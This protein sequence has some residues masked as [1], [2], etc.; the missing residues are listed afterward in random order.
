[1]SRSASI[2]RT[3]NGRMAV[4]RP[5]DSALAAHHYQNEMLLMG[6]D[7]VNSPRSSTL[8]NRMMGRGVRQYRELISTTE[9]T[10]IPIVF[11]SNGKDDY[12]QQMVQA[13][14]RVQSRVRTVR[15]LHPIVNLRKAATLSGAINNIEFRGISPSFHDASLNNVYL[16]THGAAGF[17]SNTRG[18]VKLGPNIFDHTNFAG[19]ALTIE[20][21]AGTRLNNARIHNASLNVRGA[22]TPDISGA[23]VTGD[24]R[25]GGQNIGGI[26]A[27]ARHTLEYATQVAPRVLGSAHTMF[28]D[29]I[30]TGS[31][32]IAAVAEHYNFQGRARNRD[33]DQWPAPHPV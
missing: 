6:H 9:G 7:P 10:N 28:N 14:T 25:V 4:P 26:V 17:G 30:R 13:I 2:Q 5:D 22:V 21:S 3:W 19:S 8:Y 32:K 23:H 24:S 1:M 20:A 27:A 18:N 33:H 11:Y 16:N 31:E 15:N 29:M 12:Y